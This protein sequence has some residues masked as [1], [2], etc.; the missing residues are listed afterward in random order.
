MH[1]Q[2]HFV[3]KDIKKKR[4]TNNFSR[5]SFRFS[6]FVVP[7]HPQKHRGVEQLVARQAHNLEV[8]RSSR[9]PAT[10]VVAIRRHSCP[11]LLFLYH[12]PC[13]LLLSRAY[14]NSIRQDRKLFSRLE[15]IFSGF[16]YIFSR[17]GYIF[18][19]LENN[20]VTWSEKFVGTGRDICR[21]EARSLSAGDE[22]LNNSVY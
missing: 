5:F 9:A 8:A 20:F 18:S 11:G 19:R 12:D 21:H 1:K 15:N 10:R 13:P 14:I 4:K 22:K 6:Q 3:P 2:H 17:L 7:L 16:D